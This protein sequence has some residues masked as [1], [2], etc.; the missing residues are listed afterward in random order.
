[1]AEGHLSLTSLQGSVAH[2]IELP[3]EYMGYRFADLLRQAKG[4]C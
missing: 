1:M 3:L 4:L 2:G